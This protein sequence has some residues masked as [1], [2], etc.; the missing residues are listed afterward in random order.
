MRIAFAQVFSPKRALEMLAKIQPISAP[1]I[2]LF[3]EYCFEAEH[4]GD[5]RAHSLRLRATAI[6]TA[7]LRDVRVPGGG[8][9]RRNVALRFEAGAER[10]IYHKIKSE[11]N[12][13]SGDN[14]TSNLEAFRQQN[15]RPDRIFISICNDKE[16]AKPVIV[17]PAIWLIPARDGTSISAIVPPAEFVGHIVFANGHQS[18]GR[19]SYW[20]QVEHPR[21]VG[22]SDPEP[23]LVIPPN[24]QRIETISV[25]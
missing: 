15:Q 1:D 10:K 6:V 20:M 12:S 8:V 3:P 17:P 5:L 19:S 24:E 9:C 18:P 13:V 16:N 25:A 7:M 2:V 14:S 21:V 23:R 11:L 22:A 4:L